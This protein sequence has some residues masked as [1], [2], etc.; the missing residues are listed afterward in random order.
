MAGALF[1]HERADVL[2]LFISEQAGIWERFGTDATEFVAAAVDDRIA[3]RAA[4]FGFHLHAAGKESCVMQIDVADF[5]FSNITSCR[6]HA[7][8]DTTDFG[9]VALHFRNRF[10]RLG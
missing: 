4:P 2:R 6:A 9:I 8:T 7:S 3:V 5:H 1:I 10:V